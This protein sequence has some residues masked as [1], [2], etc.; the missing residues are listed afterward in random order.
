MISFNY[1]EVQNM[2]YGILERTGIKASVIGIGG[3]GFNMLMM[4]KIMITFLMVK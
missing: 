1:K 3:V 4:K 2:E